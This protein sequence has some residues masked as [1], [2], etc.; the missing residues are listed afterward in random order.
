MYASL[1]YLERNRITAALRTGASWDDATSF[2]PKSVDRATLARQWKEH[3]TAEAKKDAE[4]DPRPVKVDPD[5]FALLKMENEEIRKTNRDAAAE[6]ERL[7]STVEKLNSDLASVRQ[8]NEALKE[9]HAGKK[10]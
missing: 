6:V 4:A 10:K 1:N 7:R 8:E 2:L 9:I 5:E 3:L